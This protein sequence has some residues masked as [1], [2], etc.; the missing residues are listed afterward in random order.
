MN[1]RLLSAL[2][3]FAFLAVVSPAHAVFIGDSSGDLWDLDVATNI[4]TN[5]GNSGVGA[6][7]DIALDPITDTLYGVTGGGGLYSIDTT[8]GAATFIGGTGAFI[9]GLT[10]DSSGTLFGSGLSPKLMSLRLSLFGPRSSQVIRL[11]TSPER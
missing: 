4:S 7:F 3:V 6:M 2:V 8:D 5:L 9:N 11:E 10:F 1:R